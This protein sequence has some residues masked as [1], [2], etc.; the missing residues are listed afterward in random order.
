MAKSP[1]VLVGTFTGVNAERKTEGMVG[2]F[3]GPE[4]MAI[5]R[6]GTR[7]LFV[8]PWRERKDGAT[9]GCVMS[10]SFGFGGTNG[11][12]IFKRV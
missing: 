5:A 7:K 12:L 3:N 8:N 11:S 10:N 6:T 2:G 9:L 4:N 1:L